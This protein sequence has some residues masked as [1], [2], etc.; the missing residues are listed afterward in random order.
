M[1]KTINRVEL[2][3]RVGTDPQMR[4]T[5]DGTAV[6]QLRLA[7]DRPRR[8]GET[9]TD[10]HTVTCWAKLA[11]IVNEYVGTGD[12]LY[13]S[14][15][16]VQNS[17]ETQD[18][19]RRHKHRD[20]RPR[21]RVPGRTKWESSVTDDGRGAGGRRLTLLVQLPSTGVLVEGATRGRFPSTMGAAPLLF[22]T[23]H[24]LKEMAMTTAQ[25]TETLLH[26]LRSNLDLLGE[27]AMRYQVE[28]QPKPSPGET[29]PPYPVPMTCKGCW[30][31]RC[32][33]WRRSSFASSYWTP[34]TTWW[35]SG[36]STRAT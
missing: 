36:L 19:Q 13:V 15:R 9:D 11:E 14:G 25:H 10:W 17:Y 6:T 16:L 8:N 33:P 1:S 35:G 7:T 5:Q 34:R 22:Q 28:T 30:P 12:R 20:S 29:F 4:Y 2:L 23:N 18:G 31:L 27:L 21:G 24:S 3:G 26:A 32:R